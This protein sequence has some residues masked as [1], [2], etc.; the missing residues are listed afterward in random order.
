MDVLSN[1]GK[2]LKI[3]NLNI[4]N[5][6]MR[7]MFYGCSEQFKKKIKAQYKDITKE[8]FFKF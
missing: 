1:F 6:N 5:V 4:Y 2:K 8:A 7:S 3:S